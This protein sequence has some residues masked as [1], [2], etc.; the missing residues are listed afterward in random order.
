[1]KN[2]I[3]IIT[4]VNDRFHSLRYLAQL[5]IPEWEKMGLRVVTV[6]PGSPF[7]P[8]D[9]AILHPDI[10]TDSPEI[11][12]LAEKYELVVN[13][14]VHDIRKTHISDHLVS[15]GDSY[16][17]PVIVKTNG[18]AGGR[19]D[20]KAT[21][22]KSKILRRFDSPVL[23]RLAWPVIGKVDQLRPW[24]DR[25]ALSASQ[26]RIFTDAG[27]VPRK[28]WSNPHFVVEK[29]LSERVGSLYSCRHWLFFGKE[30]V[31]RRSLST[32]PVVK[33]GAQIEPLDEAVPPTI[34]D[35]RRKLGFDYGKFDYG[36]VDGE[37]ILYDANRTPGLSRHVHLHRSTAT[38]L[39]AGIREF[40]PNLIPRF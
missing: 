7:E 8:A 10:S 27:K 40:I 26:Y 17:G 36:I 3:A 20:F 37:A 6:N 15:R 39:A 35:L 1:M 25:T 24:A 12:S 18:N 23:E 32:S 5:M 4:D 21:V 28:V 38:T 31:G 33:G 29:F 13:G 30:E 16:E 34:R 9:L 22:M 19:H 14:A 2:T 11:L